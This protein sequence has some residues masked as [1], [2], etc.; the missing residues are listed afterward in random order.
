MTSVQSPA[1]VVQPLA[2]FPVRRFTVEEY[3]RLGEVGV[4]T[5]DDRVELLEG[6]IV[7]K[8]IH[9]PPHDAT[10][11]LVDDGL[12]PRL[13][14][15]WRIRIQS[16]I[17]TI[18][19]EPEP[20][21]AV[22]RGDIRERLG[23]HPASKDIA[24]VIEVADTSLHRDRYKGEIYGKAEIPLYW[25]VNLMDRRIEVYSDPTGP[26]PNPGYRRRDEYGPDAAIPLVI[27]G[28]EVDRIAVGE[29]LP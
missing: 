28:Q 19:S 23:R 14:T 11:E 15:P 3:H 5:E 29:L 24:L 18:D 21:L 26:D 25:I 20:D 22:V 1:A 4:L 27:D 2:P 10:I 17:T 13:R 16:A 8:M 9:N 12:R 7:P 6:W